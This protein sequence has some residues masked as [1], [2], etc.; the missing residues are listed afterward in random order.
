MYIGPFIFVMENK[1]MKM[2]FLYDLFEEGHNVQLGSFK[3]MNTILSLLSKN[4]S[5]YHLMSI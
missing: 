5:I 3:L 2:V 1:A 4:G